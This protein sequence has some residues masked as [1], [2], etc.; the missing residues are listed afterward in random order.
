MDV[1]SSTALDEDLIARKVLAERVKVFTDRAVGGAFSSFLG[2]LL[3]AWIE[4]PVA[5]LRQAIE[6][7]F[8]INAAEILIIVWGYQ[9]RRAQPPDEEV[10]RWA[11]RQI[12]CAP[13]LGLAWG[14]SVWFFWVDGQILFYVVNL[15]VLVTVTALTLTIVAPFAS[16]T[17]LFT[18]G[19]LL[20]VLVHLAVVSNPLALQIAPGLVVLFLVQVRYAAIAR[21][22]LV[23]GLD[24]AARNACLAEKLRVG[25]RQMLIAQ[26][27]SGTGSWVY[28]LASERIWASAEGLRLFGYP[29]VARDFPIQEIEACIPERERVHQALLALI[30]KG[31][32]Y[33]LE[34]AINP[35]DGSPVRLV[36]SIARLESNEQDGKSLVLGFIQDITKS[37]QLEEQV[38]QLAFYDTLTKLA[39]RHLLSDRLSQSVVA[40]QRNA[41]FGAVMFMDL[42][43]FKPL[44]DTYGHAVGDMLLVEVANRLIQCVRKGDTV[45]RFGGD[46]FVVVLNALGNDPAVA[47]SQA[48]VVAEKIRSRLAEPYR[49]KIT[50]EEESETV[51]EHHCSASI[52]V[53]VFMDHVTRPDDLLKSVDAAMYQ[54]KQSGPNAIRFYADHVA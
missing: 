46:E 19:I 37:K 17:L 40:N 26:Q 7:F 45:A 33:D 41:C 1:L 22:Q 44:N 15:T 9:Y 20:P 11:W 34:Y 32:D 36:H 28:D 38:R 49:M 35:A 13:L 4:A 23:S 43:N 47:H 16:A 21:Q 24:T 5:G 42:D 54:A 8:C 30:G 48:Q 39:N 6:W 29:A 25:E 18:A 52:G 2:T 3:L 27:I 31:S 50:R 51:V 10:P 12:V 14:S 53:V